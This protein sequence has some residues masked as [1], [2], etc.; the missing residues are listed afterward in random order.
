M[1]GHNPPPISTNNEIAS[2]FRKWL[3]NDLPLQ[4]FCRLANISQCEEVETAQK[5]TVTIYN[6]L[7]HKVTQPVRVAVTQGNYKVTGPTGNTQYIPSVSQN[8]STYVLL[9]VILTDS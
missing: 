9:K 7:S 8:L 3:G 2:I 4:K 5:F 6:P 1:T